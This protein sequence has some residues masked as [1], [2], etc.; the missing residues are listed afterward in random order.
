MVSSAIENAERFGWTGWYTDLSEDSGTPW[1][2]YHYVGH[3]GSV[4]GMGRTLLSARHN[5]AEEALE[6]PELLLLPDKPA[7]RND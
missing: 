7:E 1:F 5:A 4:R 3:S 6:C 2:A